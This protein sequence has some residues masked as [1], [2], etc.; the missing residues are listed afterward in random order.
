MAF[1]VGEP[2][3]L[4]V[5]DPNK[6]VSVGSMN[7]ILYR[8]FNFKFSNPANASTITQIVNTIS[9]VTA[10]TTYQKRGFHVALNQYEYWRTNV[11]D[12]GPPSGNPLLDITII[13]QINNS[14]I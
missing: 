13:G 14:G 4:V 3:A 5:S 11:R 12:D 7:P 2:T 1:G 6:Y 9:Y 8:Y 10:S